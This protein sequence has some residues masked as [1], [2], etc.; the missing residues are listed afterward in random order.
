M[1]LLD[2][3]R[4]GGVQIDLRDCKSANKM[5]LSALEELQHLKSLLAGGPDSRRSSDT[6]S[7]PAFAAAQVNGWIFVMNCSNDCFIGFYKFHL[8]EMH[9]AAWGPLRSCRIPC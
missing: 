3:A 6:L 4:E 8:H 5:P 2:I 7:S 9:L 1:S